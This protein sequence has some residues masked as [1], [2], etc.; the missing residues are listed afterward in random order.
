MANKTYE[1]RKGGTPVLTVEG[2]RMEVDGMG[3][4]VYDDEN[5]VVFTGDHTYT[6]A[7]SPQAPVVPANIEGD[8]AE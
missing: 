4:R 8:V 3:I 5:D 2:S 1:V 7:K 6:V